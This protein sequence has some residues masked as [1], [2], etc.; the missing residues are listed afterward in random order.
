MNKP[1]IKDSKKVAFSPVAVASINWKTIKYKNPFI[2]VNIIR[3]FFMD[4]SVPLNKKEPMYNL[5]DSIRKMY[6]DPPTIPANVI[7][8]KEAPIKPKAPPIIVFIAKFVKLGTWNF[9]VHGSTNEVA[10]PTNAPAPAPTR[11]K[12]PLGSV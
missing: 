4:M 6:Q 12:F 11:P 10:N 9:P 8:E 5:Q 1:T 3:I 2:Y 7:F